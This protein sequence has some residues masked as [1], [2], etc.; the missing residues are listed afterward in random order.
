[1]EKKKREKENMIE[2]K[3]RIKERRVWWLAAWRR[4][5]AAPAAWPRPEGVWAMV[6]P[7]GGEGRGEVDGGDGKNGGAGGGFSNGWRWRCG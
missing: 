7:G 6:T 2:K 3:N 1:M 5:R 4:P